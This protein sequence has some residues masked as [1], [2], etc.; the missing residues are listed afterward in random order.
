MGLK[1]SDKWFEKENWATL[2]LSC[3]TD[4]PEKFPKNNYMMHTFEKGVFHVTL[5]FSKKNLKLT[6]LKSRKSTTL[7]SL[8]DTIV[9]KYIIKT[10]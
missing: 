9:D 5:T 4:W 7:Y 3:K 6:I 2:G 8:S 10:R 1:R